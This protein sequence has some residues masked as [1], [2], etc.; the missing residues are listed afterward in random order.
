MLTLTQVLVISVK[1]TEI[2]AVIP[3]AG[4]GVIDIGAA[5][6]AAVELF[7]TY[8]DGFTTLKGCRT[9]VFQ[10]DE[11]KYYDTV[12]HNLLTFSKDPSQSKYHVMRK[13]EDVRGVKHDFCL[14]FQRVK[15][16]TVWIA[17]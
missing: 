16:A 9:K 1:D 2:T 6:T 12:F 13:L 7:K 14:C 10:S 3:V 15:L 11:E 4:D 5:T 17:Q 8:L